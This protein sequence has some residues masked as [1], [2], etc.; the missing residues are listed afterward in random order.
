MENPDLRMSMGMK[1]EQK[2]VRI[3]RILPTAPESHLLKQS[4]VILSFDGVDIAN[5]GTGEPYLIQAMMFSCIPYPGNTPK[6][7][8]LTRYL[9]ILEILV[10]KIQ[11]S[12]Y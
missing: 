12:C 8:T 6:H 2:G 3:K 11:Y 10:C 5:D 7:G 4:D 9:I 1:P